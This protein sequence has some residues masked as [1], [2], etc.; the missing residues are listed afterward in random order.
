MYSRNEQIFD[1]LTNEVAYWIGFLMADGNVAA[2]KKTRGGV[3]TFALK[4]K[5]FVELFKTF[6]GSDAPIKT[7]SNTRSFSG[8]YIIHRF[9]VCSTPLVQKLIKYGVTPNK[10]H[11]AK[12]SDELAMNPHFWRGVIDGDGSVSVN[13]RNQ[14]IIYLGC[15]SKCLMQQY[16]TFVKQHVE[17]R[18]KLC[19][20]NQNKHWRVQLT[21]KPA[22]ALQKVLAGSPSLKV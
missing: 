10:T 14:F 21:G 16:L 13:K 9:Q 19:Q 8:N 22:K 18:A 5:K 1:V 15:A 20:H 17:T 11:T 4:D 3:I 6:V 12:V 2:P 7:Q